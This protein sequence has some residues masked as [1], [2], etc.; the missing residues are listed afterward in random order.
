M[1]LPKILPKEMN[2]DKV[3]VKWLFESMPHFIRIKRKEEAENNTKKENKTE[4]N[5]KKASVS[6]L[7]L[8]HVKE[9]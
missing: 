9:T 3:H 8:D 2:E 4:R 6:I 7:L 1:I 5:A